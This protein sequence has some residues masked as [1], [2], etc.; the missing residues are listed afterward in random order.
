MAAKVEVKLKNETR[1][2]SLKELP[3]V[4]RPLA[5]HFEPS[6]SKLINRQLWIS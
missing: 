6:A 1:K 4:P 2:R 5:E 3:E